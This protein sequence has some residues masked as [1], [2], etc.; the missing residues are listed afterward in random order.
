[1]CRLLKNATDGK[2][3]GRIKVTGRRKSSRKQLPDYLQ[4]TRDYW[5][6]KQQAIDRSLWRTC[7]RRVYGPIVRQTTEWMNEGMNEGKNEWMNRARLRRHVL[8]QSSR[9]TPLF[10][11][12][13][14]YISTQ[15]TRRHIPVYDIHSPRLLN[16]VVLGTWNDKPPHHILSTL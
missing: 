12:K 1:M 8:F 14:L 4:K 2:V 16:S 5:K 9:Y 11:P 10:P 7:F 3:E 6:L 15:T 13:I